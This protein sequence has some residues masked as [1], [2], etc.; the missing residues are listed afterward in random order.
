[1]E[2][3][4]WRHKLVYCRSNRVRAQR[5]LGI[6]ARSFNLI[7][8]HAWS[9]SSTVGELERLH[10]VKLALIQSSS[11]KAGHLFQARALEAKP[12]LPLK[13]IDFIHHVK[14]LSTANT[15]LQYSPQRTLY[16]ATTAKSNSS[17]IRAG[18]FTCTRC[19]MTGPCSLCSCMD[20]SG[21][22]R[23]EPVQPRLKIESNLS[24]IHTH[25]AILH[26]P[27][28]HVYKKPRH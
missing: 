18:R 10:S 21:Y 7:T 2:P 17:P 19:H 4:L 28:G 15:I 1:M 16:A 12:K 26:Q 25:I 27:D 11:A 3:Y 14:H 22:F 9:M 5:G 13:T 23:S 24:H 8:N 6:A 20:Q